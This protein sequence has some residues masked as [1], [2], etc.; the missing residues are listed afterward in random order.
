MKFIALA[1]PISQY[2]IHFG[3]EHDLP[4]IGE[5][6]HVHAKAGDL[7]LSDT[8]IYLST[9][10][11]LSVSSED[12]TVITRLLDQFPSLTV[13]IDMDGDCFTKADLAQIGQLFPYVDKKRISV[14]VL[15]KIEAFLVRSAGFAFQIW[16]KH[17]QF[18]A[19]QIVGEDYSSDEFR[20]AMFSRRYTPWRSLLTY[21][22]FE[23]GILDNAFVSHLAFAD[24]NT[25][26]KIEVNKMLTDVAA[27]NGGE[28]SKKGAKYL[29][30]PI[31]LNV[32]LKGSIPS[33]DELPQYFKKGTFNIILEKSLLHDGDNVLPDYSFVSD[34]TYHVMLAGRPF[35]V[36]SNAGWLKALRARG[37]R[38]FGEFIDE[39]YDEIEDIK[40]RFDALVAEITRL[41]KL[42][43][44]EWQRIRTGCF[45]IALENAAIARMENIKALRAP[46][47]G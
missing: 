19:N 29:L 37:Y 44:D 20:W 13:S 18:N 35:L 43:N 39:S 28:L 23:A 6:A 42:D 11:I 47:R 46:T 31:S 32:P 14:V 10:E 36:M 41:N 12:V 9:H 3:V 2:S 30:T 21:E 1:P 17:L 24:Q 7:D 5:F 22:L 25:D 34:K 45:D 8:S 4:I 26:E 33:I 38:T 40:A 15:D 27:L 16:N